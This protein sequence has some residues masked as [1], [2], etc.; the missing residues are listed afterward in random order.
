MKMIRDRLIRLARAAAA[1][2]LTTVLFGMTPQ[3]KAAELTS[4]QAKALA[5][6]AKTG[7]EHKKLTAYYGLEAGKFEADAKRHEEL[8]QIYRTSGGDTT[9]GGKNSG[10]ASLSRTF[11]NCDAVAKSLREAAKATRHSPR[12]T[13]K[14]P[15]NLRNDHSSRRR[16]QEIKSSSTLVKGSSACVR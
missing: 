15:K 6:T 16:C 13:S 10:G 2:T 1:L 12:S 14:W 3:L 8:A 4:K 5:A 9:I 11:G 7:L